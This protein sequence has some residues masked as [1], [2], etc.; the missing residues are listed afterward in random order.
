MTIEITPTKLSNLLHKS[1]DH[2]MW[3]NL[4]N[5]ILP[6]YEINTFDRIT[7][8]LAQII[9]ESMGFSRLEENLNYKAQRL[10]EVW[11]TRF[12]KVTSEKFCGNKE[13]IANIAYASR[14]GNGDVLSGDGFKYRGRGLIQL[15]G[16]TNYINMAKSMGLTVYELTEKLSEPRT[17]LITACSFWKRNGCNELA[18]KRKLTDITVIINGGRNG[19]TERKI[20]LNNVVNIFK[21]GDS[22]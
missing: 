2:V 19:L 16:K 12:S 17:A 10:C 14:M 4:L 18:D 8:F 5:Q 21:E 13:M 20:T 22:K 6:K 7:Q 11:P 3:A 15:T 1:V 9:H